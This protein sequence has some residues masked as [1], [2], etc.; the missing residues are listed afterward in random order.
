MT[1][2]GAVFANSDLF[3][4][5]GIGQVWRPKTGRAAP[6][7]RINAQRGG[8]SKRAFDSKWFAPLFIPQGFEPAATCWPKRASR[9][10]DFLRGS[11]EKT[12]YIQS[13][14][15]VPMKVDKRGISGSLAVAFRAKLQVAS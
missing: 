6:C 2:G 1:H 12:A 7:A 13:F 14:S 15:M 9:R 5:A 4:D 8:I 10:L 11:P 3:G